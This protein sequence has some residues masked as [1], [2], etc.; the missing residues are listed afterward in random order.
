MTHN[1]T[2]YHGAF[3]WE[4]KMNMLYVCF[5]L[6]IKLPVATWLICAA[7]RT[8]YSL[9]SANSEAP[10]IIKWFLTA[11]KFGVRVR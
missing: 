1:N 11:M 8:K 4:N 9:Y 3:H 7:P 5:T 6:Y 10:A 2:A